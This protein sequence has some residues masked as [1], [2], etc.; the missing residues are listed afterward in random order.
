MTAF[1]ALLRAVNVG[2]TGKLPMTELKVMCEELGFGA[3]RTY[4]ASGNVV[5]TSRKSESA[6]K[7]ALEKR[8]HA[9]AGAP[10]GVLV[11]S[12]AEMARVLADNPF[13][14]MAPNRTVAIFLDKAPPADTLA[15]IRGRKGEE[16][17]LGRREIYVHYGDG[18]GTSKLA[19]PAARA[20][21]ARNMNT[22]AT[23]VK[24]AAEL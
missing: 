24:M 22:I 7:A 6:I 8:L 23:L 11:R 17:K 16:I 18:M 2:G 19:I 15:G 10:V 13:P 12:A 9:H 1:V 3:V 21:T 5:F 20:G 4:I 14:K